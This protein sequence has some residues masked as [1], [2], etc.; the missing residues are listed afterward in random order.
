MGSTRVSDY[1]DASTEERRFESIEGRLEYARSKA[2]LG[3]ALPKLPAAVLD[4]GGATGAYSFWLAELGY[5]VT[6]ADLSARHVGIVLERN[7]AVAKPIKAAVRADAL[8]LPFEAESF[9]AVLLMGP[10]YHLLDRGSRIAAIAE[11]RRVL[12]PGGTIAAAFIS[13]Y[14]S[15]VDGYRYALFGDPAYAD[16]VREDLASGA[17]LPPP[18]RD[19]YFTEAYLH[20]PAEIPGEMADGGFEGAIVKAVEG[21]PWMLSGLQGILDDD[22]ARGLLFEWLDRTDTAPS[23]LGASAHLLAIGRK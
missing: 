3:R 16:L 9:D 6:L 21:F 14:A 11:A 8:S 7:R 2:L 1:Y 22:A 23:L 17:H 15:L 18:D 20:D 5:A 10:L 13:R 12:K 4:V 19:D